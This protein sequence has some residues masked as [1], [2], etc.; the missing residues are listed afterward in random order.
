[1]WR[2]TAIVTTYTIEWLVCITGMESLLHGTCWIYSPRGT[3]RVFTARYGLNIFTS[4]NKECL[5]RGTDW[6]YS[7]RWAWRV[8]TA[9]YGL[10]I[11]T[12]GDLESVY[13]AVR[14]ESF[15]SRRRKSNLLAI[16]W[17]RWLVRRPGFDSG[18]SLWDFRWKKCSWDSFFSYYCFPLP[19]SFHQCSIHNFIYVLLLLEEPSKSSD[20]VVYSRTAY[21]RKSAF[22]VIFKD[23]KF[24]SPRRMLHRALHIPH[25]LAT[26]LRMI[27]VLG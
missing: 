23:P 24:R 19:V 22:V 21:G 16:P 18:Q 26:A 17:L 8:F 25:T 12:S 3:W 13:C 7:H 20:A 27:S 10:N 14:T 11:F 1:M 5:L 9:R 4:R 2:W 15:H 6:I